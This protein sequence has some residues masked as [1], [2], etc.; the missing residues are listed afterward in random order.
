MKLTWLGFCNLLRN[1]LNLT[2]L[3]TKASW[4]LLR[5]LL[6]NSVEPDLALHQSLPTFSRT[7]SGTFSGTLLNL[8][9]LC[10]KAPQT[11]SGAFSGTLLDLALHES[12][13]EPSPEPCWIWPGS[14]PKP[15]RPSPEPSAPKPAEP[16]ESS[17]E[18]RWSWP[19]P[20]PVHTGSFL[21]W[22]PHWLTLL[23]KNRMVWGNKQWCSPATVNFNNS[24]ILQPITKSQVCEPGT[25]SLLH[26]QDPLVPENTKRF[27]QLQRLPLTN[28]KHSYICNTQKHKKNLPSQ[29]HLLQSHLLS[30]PS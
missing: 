16:S 17:P 4:S 29:G 25:I 28:R 23:G 10:T 2:W 22:R 6:R 11:F 24:N 15:P 21:G 3:F 20:A 26:S 8:T 5:N 30:S 1:P 18:P 19:A 12:L 9:W 14:A 13:P 7:F 27:Q